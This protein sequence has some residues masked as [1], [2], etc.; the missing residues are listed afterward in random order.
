MEDLETFRLQ[1]VFNA[2]AHAL[3]HP[4]SPRSPTTAA[5]IKDAKEFLELLIRSLKSLGVEP[6]R[7]GSSKPYEFVPNLRDVIEVTERASA[8]LDKNKVDELADYFERLRG[9]LEKFESDPDGAGAG[10]DSLRLQEFFGRMLDVYSENHYVL[11]SD[12]SLL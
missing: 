7:S 12:Q 2:V 9:R 1:L 3:K 10:E 11:S 6:D 8:N 5:Y 4:Y